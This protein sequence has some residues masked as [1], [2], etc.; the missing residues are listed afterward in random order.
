MFKKLFG[1]DN[2]AL[3]SDLDRTVRLLERAMRRCG[4]RS[5]EVLEY[6]RKIAQLESALGI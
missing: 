4:V 1:I 6:E 3:K 2:R 5:P